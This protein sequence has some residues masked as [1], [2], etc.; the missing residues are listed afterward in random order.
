MGPMTI[1]R[2]GRVI[3]M[4]SNWNPE[5]H[6]KFMKQMKQA[7][8]NFKQE[9]DDKIQCLA[10]LI[11]EHDPSIILTK[12]SLMNLLTDPEEY[13]EITH[14]GSEA[15]VELLMSVATAFP[16][17]SNP[18]NVTS[19]IIQQ[20]SDLLDQ[21]L[22][23]AF[24]Y[25]GT[26]ISEPKYS[27]IE[28]E[29]RQMLLGK[30]LKIRGDAYWPH[31]KLTFLEVYPTHNEFLV[32]ELGFTAEQFLQTLEYA[33]QVVT[34]RIGENV[35]AAK[36][37]KR[38]HSKFVEWGKGKEAEF[39]SIADMIEAFR[40]A[41]PEASENMEEAM[42]VLEGLGGQSMLRII[43]RNEVD[44]VILESIACAFGENHDFF[45][46]LP[47]WPGWPLNPSLIYEKPVISHA[48]SFYIFHI[49]L[50]LRSAGYLLE[51][52]ME[53]RDSSYFVLS[54][55]KARDE[56]LERKSL[57]LL[58]KLLPGSKIYPKL[59]YPVVVGGQ[60]QW[61]ETDGI[62]LL[63]SVLIIVEAKAAKLSVSAR[64]GSILRLKDNLEEILG[65]AHEQGMRTLNYITSIN[66]AKFYDEKRNQVLGVKSDQFTDI[67]MITV[68]YEQLDFLSAQ[69]GS[70]EKMGVIKGKEWPWAVYLNDLR[71]ICEIVEHSTEFIHYLKSRIPLND[72]INFK[73]V[74]ELD[75]FMLYLKEGLYL[76]KAEFAD[77]KAVNLIG[78]T[79]DLDS[80]YLFKEGVRSEVPKP[81]QQMPKTFERLIT[82][83]ESG[84]P[85]GF[86][87]ASLSLLDCSE[88]TRAD[89]AQ[90]IERIENEFAQDNRPHS[91]S[92]IFDD[93]KAALLL[94]CLHKDDERHI[95]HWASSY[96]DG[97]GFKKVTVISWIYP[98]SNGNIMVRRFTSVEVS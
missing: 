70:I 9:I 10:N 42:R 79:E 18:K 83:L 38:A 69:L 7:R 46:K 57:E 92:F 14:K 25:Y 33:E 21:I 17:P 50:A 86:V 28:N 3:V 96:I 61:V 63:D 4:R 89:I 37:L 76:E 55:L 53:N 87:N 74:G 16:Y 90:Q 47:E 93:Q 48:G 13:R 52:L 43:P 67:F 65:K 41:H 71:V 54:F 94:A 39:S 91:A 82:V 80:Y 59:H 49:P 84:R 24:W 11:K 88:K 44:S 5:E 27:E 85:P 35:E 95:N 64:R 31:L 58:G 2:N 40:K 30:A 23:D 26:E 45:D 34:K 77:R 81:R 98:L 66:V 8:P 19:E 15:K 73:F 29:F 97:K 12:V 51:R 20:V 36:E 62:I 78:Y 22:N 72:S 6:Q 60:E 68:S 32:K 56:Y 1:Q 75:I